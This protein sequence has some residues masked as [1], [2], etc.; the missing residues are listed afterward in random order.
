[1]IWDLVL[2]SE[3][4]KKAFEHGGFSVNMGVSLIGLVTV[5]F[6][7][8]RRRR[9]LSDWFERDFGDG[10]GGGTSNVVSGGSVDGVIDESKGFLVDLRVYIYLRC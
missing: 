6:A 3:V 9:I 7:H 5:D 10:S 4:G 2:G 8:L 1:M